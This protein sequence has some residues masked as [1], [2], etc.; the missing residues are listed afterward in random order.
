MPRIERTFD[1]AAP[2][3]VVWD[4]SVDFD[5]WPEWTKSTK[6]ARREDAGP[7]R[8]GSRATLELAGGPPSTWVITALDE[9][10]YFAWLSSQSGLTVTAEH[11]IEPRGDGSSVTLAI[12]TSGLAGI[13][14]WPYLRWV[15]RRN[16]AWEAAGLKHR[17]ESIA[18]AT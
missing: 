3:S 10:R 14:A 8:I 15:S 12:S 5:R 13:V 4:I 7:L 17:A 9:G 16:L 11:T 18:A 1:V 2:S 6:S